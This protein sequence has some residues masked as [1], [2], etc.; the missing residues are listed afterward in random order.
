MV[1][2]KYYFITYLEW[3]GKTINSHHSFLHLNYT[4]LTCSQRYFYSAIQSQCVGFVVCG[5]NCEMEEK[6]HFFFSFQILQ[7]ESKCVPNTLA[8]LWSYDKQNSKTDKKSDQSSLI[9]MKITNKMQLHRLIHFSFS[10]LHVSSDVFA[11][12]KEH[13][14]VFTLSGSIH[15]RLLQAGVLDELKL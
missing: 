1:Y 14:T 13:L 12:H 5:C 10:A 8:C 4:T 7:L 11:H 2:L 9:I 6:Q 15:P 3:S